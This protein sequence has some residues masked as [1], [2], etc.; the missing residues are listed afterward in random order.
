MVGEPYISMNWPGN[1]YISM[2][3]SGYRHIWGIDARVID[4]QKK[5]IVPFKHMNAIG[6]II[7]RVICGN[8]VIT[9]HNLVQNVVQTCQFVSTIEYNQPTQNNSLHH[10]E[11]RQIQHIFR[12]LIQYTRH[13]WYV[14]KLQFFNTTTLFHHSTLHSC[15][16][17]PCQS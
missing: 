5:D 7:S 2:K 1:V 17:P 3:W 13:L 9:N 10:I 6:Q 16:R 12:Y 15:S 14:P 4:G 8:L 11:T